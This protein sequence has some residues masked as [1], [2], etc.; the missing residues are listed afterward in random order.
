MENKMCPSSDVAKCMLTCV[1]Q[2][3]GWMDGLQF[4]LNKTK[5]AIGKFFKENEAMLKMTEQLV[6]YCHKKVGH[7]DEECGAGYRV[8]DCLSTHVYKDISQFTPVYKVISQSTTVYKDISHSTPV[9]KV[10]SQSTTVYKDISHSTPVYKVISQSTLVYKVIS[11]STPVLQGYLP[12]HPCSTRLSPSPPMSTRI[13]FSPPMSTRIS[14]S[15]PMST[16]LSPSP[17]LFYKVISQSTPVLQGYLPVHP[18]STRISFSPPMS[19]RISPSP[20]MSTRLSPSPPLFYSH[21]SQICHREAESGKAA[22]LEGKA[23]TADAI[24]WSFWFQWRFFL[25]H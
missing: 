2:K 13:S 8:C 4:S 7:V 11:Q 25:A 24:V 10:I 20:P 18:C 23:V 6:E 19:T 21:S 14:F 3:A 16:R 1:E 5:E 22:I 17:P 9:Y 12:V 15:P